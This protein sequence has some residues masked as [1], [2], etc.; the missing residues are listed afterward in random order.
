MILPHAHPA[1]LRALAAAHG[2]GA[3]DVGRFRYLELACGEGAN[4]LPL[5][6]RF[7]DAA[8]V[9][10]DRAEVVKVAAQRAQR[11]GLTNLRFA[12][13][14]APEGPFDYVVAG[15]V[16]TRLSA[17]K[18]REF[19]E[20]VARLLA[21]DGILLVGYRVLPGARLQSSL[22]SVLGRAA[23]PEQGPGEASSA[24][25]KRLDRLA[26]ALPRA[27]TPQLEL[28]RAEL[29]SLTLEAEAEPLALL[30]PDEPLALADVLGAAREVGL[31]LVTEAYPAMPGGTLERTALPDWLE[32]GFSR[33]EAEEGLDLLSGRGVRATLF[34]RAEHAIRPL[35]E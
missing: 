16:F 32:R 21:E 19:L 14:G 28:L 9:G 20:E 27:A 13:N 1:R 7:P 10:V 2:V 12:A 18:R 3:F 26:A 29:T 24:A 8:F 30:A 5:A 23:R 31:D 17:T 35:A 6:A 34:A 25:R 22:R 4:L 15:K 11:A 33:L